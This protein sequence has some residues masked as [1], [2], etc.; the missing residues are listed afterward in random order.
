MGK[1][2]TVAG[3]LG[4]QDLIAALQGRSL[5]DFVIIPHEAVS[6]IDGILI[7]NLSPFDISNTL[8]KPVYPSGR[9]VHDFFALICDRLCN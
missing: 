1:A 6:R 4:G 2:I 7:D 5:G 9:T 8:G 3:L